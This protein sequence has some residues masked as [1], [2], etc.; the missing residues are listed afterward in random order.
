MSEKRDTS[1]GTV[2][3]QGGVVCKVKQLDADEYV[4]KAL[5]ISRLSQTQSRAPPI[6]QGAATRRTHN[7][8][9]SSTTT[10]STF[11]S[12]S[13][14]GPHPPLRSSVISRPRPPV[15]T[16]QV[17]PLPSAYNAVTPSPS[18]VRTKRSSSRRPALR[19]SAVSAAGGSAPCASRV[20]PSARASKKGRGASAYDASGGDVISVSVLMPTAG[21]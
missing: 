4:T 17:C 21:L 16:R 2:S 5:P 13:S 20:S 11:A 1:G 8:P 10:R 6:L 3:V 19:T 12:G 18:G 14:A 15:S 9:L 7:A